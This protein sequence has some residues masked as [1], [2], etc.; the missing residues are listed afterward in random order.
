MCGGSMQA[1]T[2][3]PKQLWRGR[4]KRNKQARE[5]CAEH[6]WD[7]GARNDDASTMMQVRNDDA[8]ARPPPSATPAPGTSSHT[9]A[10][11]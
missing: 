10:L 9:S 6:V 8:S 1:S 7:A 11:L 2:T 3:Q 4:R 5:M